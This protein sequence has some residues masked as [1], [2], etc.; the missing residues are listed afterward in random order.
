MREISIALA[1]R[2]SAHHKLDDAV[3][4]A[5]KNG[6]FEGRQLWCDSSVLSPPR[7]CRRE[8]QRSGRGGR[9]RAARGRRRKA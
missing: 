7:A 5:F 4:L 1:K 3:L 8:S 6:Q 9:R 2:L